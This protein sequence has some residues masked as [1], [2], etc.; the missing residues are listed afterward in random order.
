MLLAAGCGGDK[1]V[2]PDPD[3]DPG[4]PPAPT[5]LYALPGPDTDDIL[6]TWS[7]PSGGATSYTLYRGDASGVTPATGTVVGTSDGTPIADRDRPAGTYYYIVTASLD[8]VEG[9]SSAEAS[10]VFA[11]GFA[12]TLNGFNPVG[13][14]TQLEVT[15]TIVST[16]E[17]ASATVQ[18]EDRSAPLEFTGPSGQGGGWRAFLDLTGVT[19]GRLR[20]GLALTDAGGHAIETSIP[21]VFNTAPVL[22]LVAPVNYTVARP[23]MHVTATCTDDS[24]SCA[25]FSIHWVDD[26]K[27][28]VQEIFSSTQSMV[29]MNVSFAVIPCCGDPLVRFLVTDATGLAD[30]VF[31]RVIIESP[32]AVAL[33]AAAT[34]PGRVLDAD[35]DRILYLDSTATDTQSVRIH[36]RATGT[37]VTLGGGFEMLRG[38][39]YLTPTGALFIQ[40]AAALPAPE[41]LLEW[42]N[43]VAT[44]LGQAQDLQLSAPYASFT[45]VTLP[46]FTLTRLN[47]LTG[48]TTAIATDAGSSGSDVASTGDVAYGTND[49]DVWL[50]DEGVGAGQISPAV[51][52]NTQPVTDGIN[53]VYSRRLSGTP[54]GGTWELE[55][56]DG[57]ATSVLAPERAQDFTRA[58]ADY[59]VNNGWVAF[60][61]AGTGGVL[62]V[63]TTSPA[64]EER[65]VTLRGTASSI[66]ALGPGG[67]VVSVNGFLHELHVPPYTDL[68]TDLG[69]ATP[70]AFVFTAGGLLKLVGNTVFTVTP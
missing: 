50:F 42:R 6:L 25:S 8:T 48:A 47:T 12:V 39:A 43:G 27:Q 62:Q 7:P 68:P 19:H 70:A 14:G 60:T 2:D 41:T 53:V 57:A 58:G 45:A 30:T 23:D 69:K 22:D 55:R 66:G 10:I 9:T 59:A 35:A 37:D 56:Y 15:V 33:Q 5:N 17:L 4:P 65:Q 61:K 49:G 36:D 29:D 38:P 11:P 28:P 21:F 26:T 44:D 52:F 51:G 3:P 46:S 54:S 63:W 24:G 20:L 31:R 40:V 67:E 32:E 1:P 18:V 13:G 64:G 34:V 16:L